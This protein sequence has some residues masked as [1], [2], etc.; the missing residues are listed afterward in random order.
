VGVARDGAVLAEAVHREVRSH[1]DT[2]PTLVERVLTEAGCAIEDLDA[3]AV[4]IGPGSFTGLRVGLALAKGIAF[5]GDLPL[6]PVPTL[7]ALAWVAGA[8]SGETVC[9]AL[10]ARKREVYAAFFRIDAGGRPCRLTPDAALPPAV[11]AARLDRGTILVGD[12]AQVYADVLGPRVTL[13]PFESHHP[14]G[15]VVARLGTERLLAGEAIRPAAGLGALEPVYVRP[16][17][18]ELPHPA[19]R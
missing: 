12:A 1:A 17:D 15:G 13:R 9:A 10:D 3:L 5:A 19:S 18:A 8:T 7:E 4:S 2:L 6:A 11:L 14:R 16:P